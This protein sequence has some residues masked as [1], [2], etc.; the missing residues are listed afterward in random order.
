MTA[1]LREHPNLIFILNPCILIND[2]RV[3]GA[4]SVRPLLGNYAPILADS[5]PGNSMYT[6]YAPGTA[7]FG[8]SLGSN[9][10]AVLL[11]VYKAR[12][13]TLFTLC[14][15]QSSLRNLRKHRQLFSK[16]LRSSRY[17]TQTLNILSLLV[18]SGTVY[19]AFWV[20]SSCIAGIVLCTLRG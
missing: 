15:K 10:A 17:T 18:E 12:Y 16:Q 5:I 4:D 9:V 19:S 6:Y 20:S 8:L 14:F 13:G 3:C 2:K 1:T 11:V 7:A